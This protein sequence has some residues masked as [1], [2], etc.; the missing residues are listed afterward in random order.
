[1]DTDYFFFSS[2]N[3]RISLK[4]RCRCWRIFI[5][6][7]GQ[8]LPVIWFRYGYDRSLHEFVMKF[9]LIGL[10]FGVALVITPA[11]AQSPP[12]PAGQ[13]GLYFTL[14]SSTICATDGNGNAHTPC[15]AMNTNWISQDNGDVT[16][17]VD[18]HYKDLDFPMETLQISSDTYHGLQ[19]VAVA[20][21]NN[22]MTSGGRI[23]ITPLLPRGTVTLNSFLMST[24]SGTENSSVQVQELG[25]NN[26]LYPPNNQSPVFLIGAN[27]TY[28]PFSPGVSSPNGLAI[29]FNNTV[30]VGIDNICFTVS[31]TPLPGFTLTRANAALI[32]ALLAGVLWG[33]AF[34]LRRRRAS[35]P[36][37]NA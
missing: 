17:L 14:D 37:K 21:G 24:H 18:V 20:R 13:R 7:G 36:G 30:N 9:C 33:I 15:R 16:G 23:E 4:Q 29:Q 19:D 6:G 25:S 11:I 31:S 28:T 34:L 26:V 10:P 2:E 1:L 8:D 3:A 22:P 5:S 27:N 12:C 32:A 35:T